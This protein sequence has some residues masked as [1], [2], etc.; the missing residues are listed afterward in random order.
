[1]GKLPRPLRV[2]RNQQGALIDDN[3][4]LP[5]CQIVVDK[6]RSALFGEDVSFEVPSYLP[7]SVSAQDWLD[8]VWDANRKMTLL[9]KFALN[10]AV[11]G[12][13]YLRIL[14]GPAYPLPR[15]IALDPALVSVTHAEDDLE[16]VLAYTL[17][18]QVARGDVPVEKRQSFERQ[19]NASGDPVAW[20]IRDAERTGDSGWV[21][22]NEEIWPYPFAPIVD[23]QNL[24]APNRYY[25]LSDLE[26]S[27]LEMAKAINR[28]VTNVARILRF[29]AHPKTIAKGVGKADLHI[30]VDDVLFLPPDAELS[31]LEMQSDLNSSL[32]FYER[33]LSAFFEGARIPEVSRGRVDNAGALSGVALRI[34]YQPLLE[35]TSDK[36]RLYGDL[37]VELNRRLLAIGGYGAESIVSVNWPELVPTDPSADAQTA[38]NLKTLGVSAATLLARLGFDPDMEAERSADERVTQYPSPFTPFAGDAGAIP[39]TAAG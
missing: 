27:T 18:W 16:D 2:V 21:L 38:L 1:M 19:D 4:I 9:Q 22:T 28:T 8:R 39:P 31:T 3:V 15:V 36:R 17:R 12:H 10:G 6:G 32:A 34:L 35:K 24:P 23:C 13:A 33:Q 7:D 26:P 11:A 14:A 37:L 29:H 5:L 20:A 30:G 25:G